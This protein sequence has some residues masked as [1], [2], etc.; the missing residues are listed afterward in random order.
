[1]FSSRKTHSELHEYLTIARSRYPKD[2]SGVFPMSVSRRAVK[3]YR[4]Q[5]TKNHDLP[6]CESNCSRGSISLRW[7]SVKTAASVPKSI[8]RYFSR[9]SRLKFQIHFINAASKRSGQPAAMSARVFPRLFRT[10]R[11]TP[12]RHVRREKSSQI[13][14][15]HRCNRLGRVRS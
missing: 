9:W 10:R 7:R 3:T 8:A 6:Q 15:S 4:K 11:I 2:G 1:M 14:A 13:T 5:R 12:Q